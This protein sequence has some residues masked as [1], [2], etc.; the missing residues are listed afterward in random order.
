MATWEEFLAHWMSHPT[1]VK[2]FHPF[3]A[4]EQPM[5]GSC[6]LPKIGM[7]IAPDRFSRIVACMQGGLQL[8]AAED[9]G[10]ILDSQVLLK[11]SFHGGQ[12]CLPL[13]GSE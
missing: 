3:G 7:L 5:A 10:C 13:V 2:T 8:S 11:I 6:L 4:V 9:I 1:L 12:S